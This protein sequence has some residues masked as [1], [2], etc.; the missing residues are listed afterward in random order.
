MSVLDRIQSPTEEQVEAW[1]AQHGKVIV[2][3][4]KGDSEFDEYIPE[5][6]KSTVVFRRMTRQDSDRFIAT[7][8]RDQSKVQMAQE[9][10]ATTCV[11][12]PSPDDLRR[13]YEASP[14]VLTRHFEFVQKASGLGADFSL[15]RR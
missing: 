1:E 11:L 9:T 3:R 10:L 8:A 14:G 15:G 12:H 4:Y 5:V 6:A 2:L 13:I 7:I